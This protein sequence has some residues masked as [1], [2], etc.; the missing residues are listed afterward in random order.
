MFDAYVTAHDKKLF[1][2]GGT[3]PVAGAQHEVFVYDMNVNE[4]DQLPLSGHCFGVP[5]VIGGRLAII[6]GRLSASKK[7]TNK[8]STFDETSQT[9]VSYYPDLLSVRNRPGVVTHLE[10]IIV[11]GGVKGNDTPE[12]LD[13]IEILNWVE[14]SHWR[15]ISVNLPEPMWAFTPI[16]SENHFVI[17]GYDANMRR[18]RSAHK[19]PI[20]VITRPDDYKQPNDTPTKWITMTT[21]AQWHTTLI[22]N[23]SPPV[24]VGGRDQNGAMLTA[25]IKMYN[26]SSKSWKNVASLSSARSSVAIAV[27]NNNAIVVIGGCIAGGNVANAKSSSLTAVELGQVQLMH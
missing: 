7:R 21:A 10:H 24:I 18:Y 6:G 9:W 11:A 3:S 12:A 4:W 14:N 27:V 8:V 23:S 15:K 2:A 13:D 19:M 16:I 25:D 1:V 26:Y 20:S 5:H 22:P 17:V